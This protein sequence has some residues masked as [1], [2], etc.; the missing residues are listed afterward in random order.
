M[1][2]ALKTEEDVRT[3]F[4]YNWLKTKGID[5]SQISLE[6]HIKLQLGHATVK[7]PRKAGRIDVLIRSKASGK[8]LIVCE[9]KGPEKPL[10]N[11][12][13]DQAVSYARALKGNM[14]PLVILSNS[15]D[16]KV[17]CSLTKKEIPELTGARLISGE[18]SNSDEDF[19]RLKE[20]AIFQIAKNP[21]YLQQLLS[22][23]SNQEIDVLTG[24]IGESRKYC[25]ESYY[26][27]LPSIDYA[28]KVNLVSGSPQSGK[29]NY[30]CDEFVKYNKEGNLC[31]FFRSKSINLGIKKALRESLIGETDVPEDMVNTLINNAIK[32]QGI[33]FFIDGLNEISVENRREIIEELGSYIQSGCTAVITCTDFFINTLKNNSIGDEAEIFRKKNED[34]LNFVK[35]PN[36]DNNYYEVIK[37]YQKAYSTQDKPAHKLRS[38]NSIGKYYQLKHSY[39]DLV[40]NNEY[41]IH[42]QSLKTKTAFLT[43]SLQR[44]A[45]QALERLAELLSLTDGAIKESDFCSEF[46]NNRFAL[47]PEV[48]ITSGML[49]KSDGYIDFY[50]ESYRDIILIDKSIAIDKD[51]SKVIQSLSE[52]KNHEISVSCITKYL[53]FH[54]V[55]YSNIDQLSQRTKSKILDAVISYVDSNKDLNE[56]PL[57]LILNIINDGVNSGD[58]SP[59]LAF[60]HL[61]RF[62]DI[63]EHSSGIVYDQSIVHRVLGYCCGSSSVSSYS[64][65]RY[66]ESG[67]YDSN[68]NNVCCDPY[69]A[70]AKLALPFL[71]EEDNIFT[72]SFV[73]SIENFKKEF[74]GRYLSEITNFFSNLIE[75]VFNYDSYMCSYGSYVDVEVT[76][77]KETGDPSELISAFHII[78]VLR[79]S[80]LK[81]QTFDST[82]E[83][84]EQYLSE[85]PNWIETFNEIDELGLENRYYQN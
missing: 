46:L 72:Y 27:I 3:I 62:N 21:E 56:R 18:F 38:I 77:F 68:I 76:N 74:N 7:V 67:M 80:L 32:N 26:Q 55:P 71:L 31:V 28:K 35:I 66:N 13:L 9:L 5:N 82:I 78:K 84:L 75:H 6:K 39:P 40:L 2:S 16:I 1:R 57:N 37:I 81:S 60:D 22:R 65:I 61:D 58:V 47:I 8:N 23:I 54:E 43:D 83:Y 11:A 29:T 64:D 50:D 85:L 25:K 17:Y 79:N 45:R 34:T 63:I 69:I 42:R 51:H 24:N 73:D 14:A 41:T 36:L 59:D 4:F 19:N 12:T 49:D 48:F 52:I 53:C 15:K 70:I 30:I 44:C 20:E 10:D 33:A